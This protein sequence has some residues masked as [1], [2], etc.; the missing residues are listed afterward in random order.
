MSE[1]MQA[2][3]PNT[4]RFISFYQK[5][6]KNKQVVAQSAHLIERLEAELAE[7]RAENE[8]IKAGINSFLPSNMSL[9]NSNIPDS[10]ELQLDVSL[11][12]LRALAALTDA[13]RE[14][15]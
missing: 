8:R 15:G 7:A 6:E 1:V 10:L 5:D 3:L 9:N 12:E 11:G 4:L 2:D 14:V 13:A